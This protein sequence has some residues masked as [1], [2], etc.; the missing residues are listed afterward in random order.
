[1]DSAVCRSCTNAISFTRSAFSSSCWRNR[2]ASAEVSSASRSILRACSK[3]N[4]CA[5]ASLFSR[6]R[7]LS[8]RCSRARI[9]AAYSACHFCKLACFST[10]ASFSSLSSD[11]FSSNAFCLARSVATN[12]SVV[13]ASVAA[14]FCLVSASICPSRWERSSKSSCSANC[15][16]LM[17]MVVSLETRDSA[18][19]TSL[20]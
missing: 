14:N 18:W 5:S 10:S 2:P 19:V 17:A 20:V 13:M 11:T 4:R 16:R 12:F 1:M 8:L 15:S 7:A 3:A 9:S 6:A